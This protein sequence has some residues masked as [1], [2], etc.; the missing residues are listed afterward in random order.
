[1]IG[2]PAVGASRFRSPTSGRRSRQVILAHGQDDHRPRAAAGVGLHHRR[3]QGAGSG[4]G[5]A[6][7]VGRVGVDLIQ[8]AIDRKGHLGVGR[9]RGQDEGKA[10]ERGGSQAQEAP[11]SRRLRIHAPTI[12][13][14]HPTCQSPVAAPPPCRAGWQPALFSPGG[15]PQAGRD[16]IPPYNALNSMSNCSLFNT[17]FGSNVLWITHRESVSIIAARIADGRI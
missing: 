17:R 13:D 12:K 7:A 11:A 6:L 4:A 8:L 10:N 5:P 15:I 2:C 14:D 16:T 3:A 1:M 9:W